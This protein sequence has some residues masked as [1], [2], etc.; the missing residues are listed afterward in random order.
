[1]EVCR[2]R[3]AHCVLW[4]R[5]SARRTGVAVCWK[6]DSDRGAACAQPATPPGRRPGLWRGR[7]VAGERL[8]VG[9]DRSRSCLLR[10]P[11]HRTWQAAA[12]AWETENKKRAEKKLAVLVPIGLHE[13]RHTF[14]SLLH[15]AGL[16]L[17]RIGDYVGHSSTYMTDR[18]RHLLEGHETDAAR[19]LDDYLARAETAGRVQQLGS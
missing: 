15:D 3:E 10:G 2:V 4:L 1:L 7:G 11:V 18:Y 12:N 6:R 5:A 16:S 8:I 14:I 9:R 13:C 17:E 19:L